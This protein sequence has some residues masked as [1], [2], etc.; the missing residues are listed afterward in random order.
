M[1]RARRLA[2]LVPVVLLL[3]LPACRSGPSA[4]QENAPPVIMSVTAAKVRV[5]P[6]RQQLRLLGTTVAQRHITLVAPSSGRVIDFN[7][8]DGDR[9]RAGQLVGYVVN[10]EVIAAQ[11]GLEVARQIDPA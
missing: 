11:Q 4:P 7:L 2:A 10:R 1:T 5:I 9:V 3:N 6:M 8:Q